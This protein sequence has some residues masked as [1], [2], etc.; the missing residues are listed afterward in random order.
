MPGIMIDRM[1]YITKPKTWFPH[2]TPNEIPGHFY[3]KIYIFKDIFSRKRL[4]YI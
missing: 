4:Q 2:T 3:D 1:K